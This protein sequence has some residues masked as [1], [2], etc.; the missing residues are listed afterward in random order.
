MSKVIRHPA[1]ERPRKKMARPP[2]SARGLAPG[3]NSSSEGAPPSAAQRESETDDLLLPIVNPDE[4]GFIPPE[5]T[6][7]TRLRIIG[8]RQGQ[9]EALPLDD[10][11]FE[12]FDV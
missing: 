12:I 4:I 5:R 2:K 1:S 3:K 9:P 7:K 8:F 11:D 6:L 10:V